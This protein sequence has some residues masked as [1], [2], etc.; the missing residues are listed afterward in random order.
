MRT[1]AEAFLQRIRAFPDDD[2]P[3]LI[4][5]D[6]L[7]EQ[8]D[9]AAAARAKFIRVQIAL[10]RL[11]DETVHEKSPPRRS[12]RES[13]REA[14]TAADR[15]LRKAFGEEWAAPFR[16]R[17]LTTYHEFRRGFVEMVRI[18]ARQLIR[19][20]H[21]LFAA[22][23][24]REIDLIDV[25][26]SLQAALRCQYLSRLSTLTIARQYQRFPLARGIARA[27]HLAGLKVLGL[28]RNGF[29][30]DAAEHLAASPVLANLEELDLGG[31]ELG[32]TGARA[33][34]ASPHLGK[35]RVMEL[36][37]NRL[38]PAGAEALA[39]SERLVSLH[40]LGLGG[41]EIGTARLHAIGRPY[42]LLRVPVL[43]LS[44]N[45]LTAPELLAILRRPPGPADPGAVRLAELDLSHNALGN[46]GARVLAA[47]P[48]LAGLRVLNLTWCDIGDEGARA[49]AESPHLNQLVSLELPNNPLGDPGFRPF[50]ETPHL[51]SL[52][53][54]IVPAAGVSPWMKQRLDERF[55]LSRG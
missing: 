21:E 12:E 13:A 4:F 15:N 48:H 37:N 29:E 50:L 5:A 36:Q 30:D 32:E 16:V 44:A 26:G 11:D 1:E 31:N 47:S 24:I 34:A 20:A 33:L 14:L 17:Q 42:D 39:G 27:A 3:R 41:N 52:C 38:G 54:L 28:E 46:D 51:R 18:S 10:A 19:R 40:R 25:G 45:G 9:E 49:L 53:R 6:W 22:G 23:P 35:L 55:H 43:N 8:G 7:E 2:T